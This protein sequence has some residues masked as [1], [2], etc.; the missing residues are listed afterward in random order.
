MKT[1]LFI[2][3][4]QPFHKGHLEIIKTILKSNDK[5]IIVI[6]SAEKN[7]LPK[8]PLTAGERHQ[9]ITEALDEAKITPDKYYIIPIRNINNYALWVHH[10]NMYLPPYQ[11]V[12]TGSDIVKAC[13]STHQAEIMEIDKRHLEISATKIRKAMIKDDPWEEFVPKSTAKTLHNWEI[14]TRVRTIKDT[15]DVAKY[16]NSY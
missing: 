12:Y 3:R 6:G 5:V 15:M 8:N 2:G 16:N 1:A 14:P 13:Y 10:L 7:F 9:I 4:F 11:Q